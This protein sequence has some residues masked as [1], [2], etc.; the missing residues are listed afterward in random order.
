[1]KATMRRVGLLGAGAIGAAV[2][3]AFKAGGVPGHAL[4]AI[5]ARPHQVDALEGMVGGRATV[6][7][8]PE[9][10]LTAEMDL[11]VEAAGHAAAIALGPTVV[12][13]GRDLVLV[14]VGALA[15]SDFREQMA[16]SAVNGAA[17]ILIPSGGFA[18]F[19]GLRALAQMG[20]TEVSYVST[21]PPQA[22]DGTPGEADIRRHGRDGQVVLFDGAAAGAA[23]LFPK[24]ANLA[25]AV[26]IAGLG[27]EKTRVKLISDPTEPDIVGTLTARTEATTLVLTTRSR[28]TTTNPK[29][30]QLV[31][32]SI[33]AALTNAGAALAF[34]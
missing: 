12:M 21:K 8:E 24:N 28:P 30:S 20:L 17:R 1:M 4:T 2:I 18:G 5:L 33:L 15:N 7:A 16:A 3:D 25:A 13:G 14:S 31:G 22:W 32:G 23:R 10:F 29:S 11:V 6:T 9:T 19:D 26:A 34:A 27:F